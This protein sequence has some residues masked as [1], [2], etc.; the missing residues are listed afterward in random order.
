MKKLTFIISLIFFYTILFSQNRELLKVQKIVLDNGLT[1]LLNEDH[2][3]AKVFGGVV[4]KAGSKN[5]PEN[6]T[7]L[8]HYFEHIMFKGTDSIGTIDYAA[9]KVYLDSITALYDVLHQT[10]DKKERQR[11]QV[12][13]N[14][15]SIK[16]AEYA[17]PNE[18]DI[19]LKKHGG[20]QVN[21]YTSYDETVYHNAFPPHKVEHWLDIYAERFRNPV[22]RLFQ[23]ELETVYEER[24]MYADEM[25]SKLMEEVNKLMFKKHPYRNPVI[26]TVE[27]LKNPSI[28]NIIKFYNDY[29]V[30]NNMALILAGDFDTE[31]VLPMIK[32]KF[33]KWRKGEV[34][35]FP[36]DKYKEEPYKEREFHT[37]RYLPIKG[38]MVAYRAVP[39]KHKD[40]VA[41][42][43]CCDIL[44]HSG[45]GL[46]DVLRNENKVMEAFTECMQYNDEGII[47]ITVISK[48]IGGK[49][50][51]KTEKMIMQYIDS[52]KNGNFSD[53]LINS[54]KIGYKKQYAQSLESPMRRA[55]NIINAFSAGY[56]WEEYLAK[57]ERYSS[58][59]KEEIVDAAN[60]Y[61]IDNRL[62]FYNKIGFN[63][64]ADKIKKP[65]YK[66]IVPKNAEKKSQFATRIDSLK[67]VELQPIFIDFNKD[68]KYADIKDKIHLI[69]SENPVNDVFSLQITFG[70]GTHNDSILNV[71]NHI[72]ELGTETKTFKEFKQALQ[73]LGI[74]FYLGSYVNGTYLY[75]SGFDEYFNQTLELINELFTSVK[76]DN[77][78]KS[79][80]ID[81]TKFQQK[82]EKKDQRALDDAVYEY[83][84]YGKNSSYIDR[85]NIKELK[86]IKSE[87]IVKSFKNILNYEAQITY[88]GTLPFDQIKTSILN[89]L[90]FAEK[91]NA[92]D[93]YFTPKMEYEE[94]TIFVY[95]NSKANQVAVNL[96]IQGEVANDKS[97][98]QAVIFNQYFGS[99]MSSI[100]FQEIREFRSLSYSARGNYSHPS[101]EY[102]DRKGQ[103][104]GELSTQADKTNEAIALLNDLLSNM[105]EKPERLEIIKSAISSSINS[106]KPGFRNVPFYGYSLIRQGYTEDIRKLNLE[107]SKDAQFSEIVDFYNNFIKGKRINY[108]ITGNT[109][110]FDINELEKYGKIKKLNNSLIFREL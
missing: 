34:P 29:Y 40:E 92:K 37:G 52:L 15:L 48:I 100:M 57:M 44:S 53:E 104:L 51:K 95:N 77:K 1:V 54:I 59:T 80:F 70:T 3:E 18:V 101:K 55:Y 17:I 105:P 14:E 85:L 58:I 49:S 86:K 7:G 19:L 98:L 41:L 32:E 102:P 47:M 16:S 67:S 20:T 75:I 60:R 24:N 91:L 66:P 2:S 96:Y 74:T 62:V 36:S 22:F 27:D 46:L 13:I 99:G 45:T 108:A 4:V 63:F 25:E 5:D 89:Y 28:S 97:R 43:I 79:K 84:M 68:F 21:A 35:V 50:L 83:M 31:T 8:A 82:T 76:P 93:I 9:E 11:L 71:I 26:G 23:S 42:D 6:A 72:S 90:P 30:A 81:N 56:T 10:T 110:K 109:K 88:V 103:F 87:D 64:K 106:S 78:Q 39:L 65:P 69:T 12:K 38:E 107:Y 73:R 61:F 94:N 33:G